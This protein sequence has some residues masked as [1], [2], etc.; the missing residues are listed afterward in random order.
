MSAGTTNHSSANYI[1]AP[2]HAFYYSGVPIAHKY[3]GTGR[4]ISYQ[5]RDKLD[6]RGK[7]G[8]YVFLC[9]T[10]QEQHTEGKEP[11]SCEVA[12]ALHGGKV[13]GDADASQQV[14]PA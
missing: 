8:G 13:D 9:R 11:D 5:L 14:E 3:G 4:R 1:L 10:G 6:I 2:R 7:E 12:P